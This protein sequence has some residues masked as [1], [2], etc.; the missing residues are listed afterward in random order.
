MLVLLSTMKMILHP[1]MNGYNWE[2]LLEYY[3]KIHH[4]DIHEG[5]GHNPE[6]DMYIAYYEGI[7]ENEQKV[8]N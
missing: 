1:Y 2:A 5:I 7:L 8:E 4:P 6:A 3:L